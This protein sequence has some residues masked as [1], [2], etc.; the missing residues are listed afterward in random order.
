MFILRAY[1]KLIKK[2][3]VVKERPSREKNIERDF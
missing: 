3:Y 1:K 2:E